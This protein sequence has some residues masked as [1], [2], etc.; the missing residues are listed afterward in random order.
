MLAT[1][2]QPRA[3][4]DDDL[5]VLDDLR[6]VTPVRALFDVAGTR[7][8]HGRWIERTLDTMWAM[9]IVDHHTL[10]R[11][12]HRLAERGRSGIVL[13]RELI[14][15][16][17]A[18][19]RPPESGL[20]ARF[21]RL[22]RLHNIDGFKRQVDI[23]GSGW[24]GRVDFVHTDTAVVVQIDNSRFHGSLIDQRADSVQTEALA[25]A[26]W[27]VVRVGEGDLW[28]NEAALGRRIRSVIL[29]RSDRAA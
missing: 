13:M 16:R 29:S 11:S 23:G 10:D 12:L 21:G 9:G 1:V 19:H 3:L 18:D 17:S 24:L 25:A 6:V 7:R 27:H 28:R 5:A 20:E 14:E 26:G 4:S 8:H 22:M 2:H 15:A